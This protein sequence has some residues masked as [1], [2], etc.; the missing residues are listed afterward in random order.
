MNEHNF[1]KE[2]ILPNNHEKM[3]TG[4]LVGGH[5]C[6]KSLKNQPVARQSSKKC[7]NH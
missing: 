1:K 6:R 3:A 7:P 5:Q 4:T 2:I